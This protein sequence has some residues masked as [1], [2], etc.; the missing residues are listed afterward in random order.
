MSNNMSAVD[1]LG[2]IQ[3]MRAEFIILV[4]MFTLQAKEQVTTL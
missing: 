2:L 1:L 4:M 3:K